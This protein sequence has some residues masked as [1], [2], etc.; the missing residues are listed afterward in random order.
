MHD[1]DMPKA[2]KLSWRDDVM[3]GP[4]TAAIAAGLGSTVDRQ[5]GPPIGSKALQPTESER[6]ALLGNAHSALR[7]LVDGGLVSLLPALKPEQKI[8]EH[9]YSRFIA[10]LQVPNFMTGNPSAEWARHFVRRTKCRSHERLAHH[11]LQALEA[12]AH[13]QNRLNDVHQA[14]Y[15]L[16]FLGIP[17]SPAGPKLQWRSDDLEAV[18]TSEQ[19]AAA[20]GRPEVADKIRGFSAELQQHQVR[21]WNQTSVLKQLGYKVGCS[22]PLSTK[23][24]VSLEACVLLPEARLPPDQRPFWGA[25]ATRRRVRAMLHMLNLFI[26][27]AKDRRR[28]DWSVACGEW[29]NDVEWLGSNYPYC[30]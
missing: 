1:G 14:W 29:A 25:P 5:G 16:A 9:D 27:L 21:G 28:G 7:N 8:E 6:R 23:R 10:H 3:T 2:R 17:T 30:R 20:S 19:L 11:L 4:K 26:S 15:E 12:G 24:R 13:P 18:L 22:G